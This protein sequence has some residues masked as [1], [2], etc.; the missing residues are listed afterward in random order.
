MIALLAALAFQCPDGSPPP[1]ARAAP[2]TRAPGIAAT[3]VAVLYFDNASRDS[4]DA[5]LADGITEEIIS[6]LGEVGRIQVKS[7]YLVRRWRGAETG[8]PAD[9]GRELAV[10][11]IVTGS[12]RRAGNR[13]RVTAEMVRTTTGDVVWSQRYDRADTDVLSLQEDLAGAVATAITGRLLPAER[14]AIAAGLTTTNREAW[15]HFV[16]GNYFLA[17]RTAAARALAEYEAAVR[18]DPSFVRALARVAYLYGVVAWRQEALNGTYPDSSWR[19]GRQVADRAVRAD[20]SASDA[21]MALALAQMQQPESVAAARTSIERALALDSGNAEARHLYA[22]VHYYQGHTAEAL[23]EFQRALALEPGRPVTLVMIGWLALN[24]RRLADARRWLDSAAAVDRS[25]AQ[26]YMVR[27]FVAFLQRDTAAFRAD[28]NLHASM[29]GDPS[30]VRLA[31]AMV[32]AVGGNRAPLRAWV[33][34]N[35]AR[36]TQPGGDNF[37]P[38]MATAYLTLGDR[39][40]A[41]ATLEGVRWKNINFYVNCLTPPLDE[42]RGDPRYERLVDQWRIPA[43]RRS[44]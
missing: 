12:V 28:A 5:Y 15:D 8:N 19:L 44:P 17:Q 13:V 22:W 43:F 16:R 14:Q 1:C 41:L 35:A 11:S 20:P 38:M 2:A 42:L 30:R 37:A 27:S 25:F 6:R 33:D 29:I 3:S 10:A 23:A 36:M 7:R 18:L 34:S 4:S 21:W 9:I 31:Q 24:E 39:E 26:A 40:W 32:E